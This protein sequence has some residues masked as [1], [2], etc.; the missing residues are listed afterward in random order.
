MSLQY[1][2]LRPTSGWDRLAASKSQRV[3][4]ASWIRYWP[5]SLNG[6]Q[7][8]QLNFARC[9]AI[10]WATTLCIHFR[11]FCFLREFF[12]LQNSLC[13]QILRS[14]ILAALLH[15]TRAAGVSQNLRHAIRS[16]IAELSQR[17]PPI[18]GWTAITLGVDPLLCCVVL[19]H[20][21]MSKF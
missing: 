7:P 13:L 17:A 2:E 4:R 9:L 14:P 3:L 1:G 8:N 11:G 15:G 5:T 10:S 6:G 19:C 12:Q 16:G 18:F 20:H 21:V